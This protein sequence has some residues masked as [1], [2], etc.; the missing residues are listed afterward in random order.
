M[1]VG[2]PVT[3]DG[4]FNPRPRARGD[5]WGQSSCIVGTPFQ[6]TPPR[7]GRQGGK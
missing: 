3:H 7:E 5:P 6:S 2:N 4:G 1:L